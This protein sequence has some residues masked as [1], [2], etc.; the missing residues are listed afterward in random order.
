[1]RI[2]SSDCLS[3]RAAQFIR[4]SRITFCENNDSRRKITVTEAAAISR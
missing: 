3:R 4:G 2:P 1:M